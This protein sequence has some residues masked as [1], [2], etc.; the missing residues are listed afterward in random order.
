MSPEPLSRA[1]KAWVLAMDAAKTTYRK[2]RNL[3]P[4]GK[5]FV[6]G[7]VFFYIALATFFIVVKPSVIF[8]WLY[9]LA[10]K[11]SHLRFGWLAL[12][13]IIGESHVMLS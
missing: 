5:A 8:Q 10:Q 12:G 2:Y 7:A 9:D 1:Q 11:L 3:R 4:M 6:W 13:G